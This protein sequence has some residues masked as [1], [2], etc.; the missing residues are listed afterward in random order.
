MTRLTSRSLFLLAAVLPWVIMLG[1]NQA[2]GTP[3]D[4]RFADRCTRACHNHG[5]PHDPVLPDAIASNSGLFGKAISGL[6]SAGSLTGLS[7]VEG[8]GAANLAIFCA[9]WPGGML[10]LVGIGLR[11]RVRLSALESTP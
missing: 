6:Y 4:V 2:L 8:Y 5:C 3:T 10:A 7:A 1:T 9:L 11:Q